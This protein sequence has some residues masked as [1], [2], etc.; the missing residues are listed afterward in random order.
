MSSYDKKIDRDRRRLLTGVT[1]AGL[2]GLTGGTSASLAQARENESQGAEMKGETA[3]TAT[4]PNPFEDIAVARRGRYET[5]PLRQSSIGIG[6]VQSRVKSLDLTTLKSSLRA[7]MAHFLK[8][9][10][11]AQGSPEEWG[12]E[13]RWGFKKDLLCFHEF[14]IQGWNPWNRKELQRIAFEL[15]GPESEA[16]GERAKRYGCYIS[17]G[18]YA[19]DPAWPGHIINMSVLTGPD[20]RIVSKQW[21]ARNI[22]GLFGS[23][24][25]IGSTVYNTLDR[26]VEMY[27]WDAT[28]PVARTD[29]GNIAMTAV[30]LEPMLYQCLALKG[31]EILVMSVTG[32]SNADSAMQTARDNRIYTLGVGNSVSPDNIG[33]MDAAGGATE[34]TVVVDPRG[35]AI[36]KTSNPH[37][38][39]ASARIPLQEFRD[40]RR[41]REIPVAMLLPVLQ[42]YEPAFQPGAFLDRLPE[43]Y[44]EA[45][46]LLRERLED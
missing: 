30:G 37:E 6:A 21:K 24:A 10:D 18:C 9:V 43:T 38:D 40:T 42:Q 36:G 1:A 41:F 15:P 45:G 7:N 3:G 27:G 31:A 8:L 11:L 29:I 34:G 2:A 28:L 39:M 13:R 20:G 44:E 5:V 14:P 19:K 12:F 16:I 25:L 4:A 32:G 23:S 26:F 35:M 22:L 33:F 17:W 46:A